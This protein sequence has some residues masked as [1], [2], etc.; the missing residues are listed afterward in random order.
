MKYFNT[1]IK[2][3]LS[4]LKGCYLDSNILAQFIS[5]KSRKVRI[6]RILRTIFNRAHI[7]KYQ[8]NIP[9]RNA[10]YL[11]YSL[12]DKKLPFI[13]SLITG[14]KVKV[15]GRL[16]TQRVVPRKTINKVDI[17]GVKPNKRSIMEFSSFA[18]KNRRGRFNVKV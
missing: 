12:K 11:L 2:L 8:M 6:F 3:Q 7:Y 14:I 18:N 17:G 16:P 9:Y 5:M 4:F 13:P 1:Q 10:Y 15:S